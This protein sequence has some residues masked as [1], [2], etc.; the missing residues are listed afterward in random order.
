MFHICFTILALLNRQIRYLAALTH[1]TLM[2]NASVQRAA[3]AAVRQ[4]RNKFTIPV[5]PHVKKFI[6]KYYKL[7]DPARTEEYNAFGKSV[8]AA[9]RD[10]RTISEN[11]DQYR[12]RL[13][14]TLTLLLT[15][16]QAQLGPRIPKLTRI[17]V[18]MDRLFKDHMISWIH[19]L[20]VSGLAPFN[21][22]KMFLQYYGIDDSEYSL[23]AAYK[24]WQR[25]KD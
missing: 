6:L 16:D 5:Y 22:C 17:N 7:S 18:D 9:L 11:N 20:Q 12:D 4:N 19:A 25:S 10:N 13:T 23:D 14:A 8:T 3:K 1:Y 24:F 21:A 2:T 15:K